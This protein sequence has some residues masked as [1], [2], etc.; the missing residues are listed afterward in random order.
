MKEEYENNRISHY[1]N[2]IIQILYLFLG[3]LGIFLSTLIDK[4]VLKEIVLIGGWV[5]IWEMI[6]LEISTEV[7]NWK[8]RKKIDKLISSEI[9]NDKNAL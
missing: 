3:I 2:N 4:Q 5:L 6:Q 8:I 9:I 1:H 7:K